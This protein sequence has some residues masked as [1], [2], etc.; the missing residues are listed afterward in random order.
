MFPALQTSVSKETTEP[1]IGMPVELLDMLIDE[2]NDIPIRRMKI[3]QK[4]QTQKELSALITA[5]ETYGPT[6]SLLAFANHDGFL[7][8]AVSS[9]PSLET[10]S[11]AM[12]E[13]ESAQIIADLKAL[14]LVIAMNNDS[15]ELAEESYRNPTLPRGAFQWITVVTLMF[16]AFLPGLVLNAAY[17]YWN[18]AQDR[19][20]H[21]VYNIPYNLLLTYLKTLVDLPEIL[22]TIASIPLPKTEDSYTHFVTSVVQHTAPLKAIGIH[23][24]S[25]VEIN[26]DKLK[27]LDYSNIEEAGYIE[28][29][30]KTIA[31]ESRKIQS[32]IPEIKA[33]K[34]KLIQT[35]K[36]I[37]SEPPEEAKHSRPATIFVEDIIRTSLVRMSKILK[38]TRRISNEIRPL[39][40]KKSDA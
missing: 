32:R 6:P 25:D 28:S 27:S 40:K 38:L 14:S 2:Q 12:T 31:E 4:S 1:T 9:I 37:Q 36:S 39:Y 20:K 11:N 23:V 17:V 8:T 34:E 15:D 10:L 29:S 30:L 13:L 18:M 26:V 19:K 22:K 7:G 16:M 3:M 33:L 24:E 5:I 21:I 35:H